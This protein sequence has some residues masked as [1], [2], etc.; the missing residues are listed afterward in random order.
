M[1]KTQICV[2]RPQCVKK[3]PILLKRVTVTLIKVTACSAF[4][5]M[6]L[7]CIRSY[8]KS[9]SRY[10]VLVLDTYHTHTTLARRLGTMVFF[11]V[12]RVPLADKFGRH[13][14]SGLSS[15]EFD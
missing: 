8:L 14:F 1:L 4:L 13:C 5:P 6:L 15:L 11:T 2:T 7:V 9:V 3:L 10:K 12:K